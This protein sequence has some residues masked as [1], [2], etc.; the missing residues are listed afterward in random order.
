MSNHNYTKSSNP[1]DYDYEEEIPDDA[2]LKNSRRPQ[3]SASNSSNAQVVE[4]KLLGSIKC[5]Q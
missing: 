4:L 5:Q 2:F 3:S 1:F